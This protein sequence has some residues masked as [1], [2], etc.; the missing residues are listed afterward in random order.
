MSMQLQKKLLSQVGKYKYLGTTTKIMIE[1][2]QK[3]QI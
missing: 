1:K 2:T 3:N